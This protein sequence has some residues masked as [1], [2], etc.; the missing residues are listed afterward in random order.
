MM[1]RSPSKVPFMMQVSPTIN[2]WMGILNQFIKERSHSYV[3]IFLQCFSQSNCL[4][5]H[6]ESVHEGKKPFK[7]NNCDTSFSTNNL[8]INQFMKERSHSNVMIVLLGFLK[9]NV[10]RDIQDQFVKERNSSNITVVMHFLLKK[11]MSSH[12]E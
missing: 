12:I 10:W 1:E 11:D 6:I 2:L 9:E 8:I 5:W 7:C 4:K 3:L